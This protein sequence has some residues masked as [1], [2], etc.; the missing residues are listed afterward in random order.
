M[1]KLFVHLSIL[2]LLAVLLV[3]MV[4][5]KKDDTNG[6]DTPMTDTTTTDTTVPL[7]SGLTTEPLDTGLTTDLGTT[8]PLGTDMT[9]PPAQ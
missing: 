2:C 7:D 1:K 6:D 5:C 8:E 9:T 3:P 4:G